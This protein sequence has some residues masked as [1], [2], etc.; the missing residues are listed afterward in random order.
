M[1]GGKRK[2]GRAEGDKNAKRV[3]KYD[4]KFIKFG[5]TYVVEGDIE[6]P[7]CIIC[8]VVLSAESMKPNKL[9]Q[10]RA[11]WKAKGLLHTA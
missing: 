9:H 1:D 7:Q 8:S 11:S 5:F 3:R 10:Q 2:L 6:K 4:D